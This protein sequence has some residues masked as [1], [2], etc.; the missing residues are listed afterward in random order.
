VRIE[1]AGPVSLVIDGHGAL[2]AVELVLEA[3]GG[4]P[5]V[6][7]EDVDLELVRVVARGEERV[8]ELSL[9]RVRATQVDLTA[10]SVDA[11]GAELAA[12]RLSASTLALADVNL[13]E[14]ALSADVATV[15]AADFEDVSTER[16]GSLTF[17]RGSVTGLRSRLG[18]CTELLRVY[19]A[20]VSLADLSG[21]LQTD[22]AS[23]SR[24]TLGARGAVSVDGFALK[25]MG[26]RLCSGGG[27]LRF[28]DGSAARCV[29]CEELS[30]LEPCRMSSG[31][32]EVLESDCPSFAP[33]DDDGLAQCALPWP[34]TERPLGR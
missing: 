33:V 27:P 22:G 31:R 24:V 32:V 14:V 34:T 20:E 13:V 25:L 15:A 4:E 3:R 29:S 2:S 1:L 30:A 28:G 5:R 12:S 9:S 18:P 8:G 11:H 6:S 19:D 21:P 16:C 17:A 10:R 7:I 23:L 26:A